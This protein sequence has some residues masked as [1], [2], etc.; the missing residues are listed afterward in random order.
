MDTLETTFKNSCNIS[1]PIPPITIEN[2]MMRLK[3]ADKTAYQK[4]MRHL[5]LEYGTSLHCNRFP[6]GNC[7]EYGIADVVRKTGLT[8]EEHAN[9]K[10]IDLDVKE[11]RPFSIKYT[12]GVE[13]ILHNSQRKTN[14]DMT[15]HDTLIVTP[16][17]WW[18]LAPSVIK[19]YGVDLTKYIKNNG[20][21]LALKLSILT[22]LKKVKYPHYFN[23]DISVDKS[24][25]KHK[26]IS[27]VI[28]DKLCAEL[29]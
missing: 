20:D 8:V 2:F 11:F 16:S 17:Q 29:A 3:A 22:E 21:S 24:Q 19:E 5:F 9:A 26:E 27:R 18:F 23:F 10:R 28:Y 12:S 7:N 1:S 14:T 6:I 25:C 13:A 15:M 4:L